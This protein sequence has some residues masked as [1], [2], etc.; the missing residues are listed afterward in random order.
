[1]CGV[2]DD[3]GLDR[4]GSSEKIACESFGLDGGGV[5]ESRVGDEVSRG[6]A[7]GNVFII[8]VS[9]LSILSS[10]RLRLVGGSSLYSVR[11]VCRE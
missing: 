11:L 8:A 5:D 7:T 2:G 9:M 3:G 10:T 4:G 6:C 1:M